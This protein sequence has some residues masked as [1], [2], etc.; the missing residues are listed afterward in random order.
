MSVFGPS[1]VPRVSV[2]LGC[3]H[4]GSTNVVYV[5]RQKIVR[6]NAGCIRNIT[7]RQSTDAEKAACRQKFRGSLFAHGDECDP[8]RTR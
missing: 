1:E 5:K 3:L 4:C 2:P 6:H 7:G 8:R